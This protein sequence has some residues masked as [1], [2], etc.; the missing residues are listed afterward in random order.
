MQ[1]TVVGKTVTLLGSDGKIRTISKTNPQAGLIVRAL[2]DG[3]DEAKVVN[4]FD[5][6]KALEDFTLG[7]QSE[8]Q[9]ISITNTD[10]N[11]TVLVRNGRV[12]WDKNGSEEE[13]GGVIVDRIR[14]FMGAGLN[15]TPL[16]RFLCRLMANPSFNSRKQLYEFL[17]ALNMPITDR[18]TFLACKGL[19]IDYTDR[20]TGKFDNHPGVVNEMPRSAV[21]ENPNNH[22]S[23][24]F[25]VGAWEYA[26]TFGPK[27]V[28][29]E[30]DPADVVSVPGDHNAQKCRVTRYKVLCDMTE[31]LR[32]EFYPLT[33]RTP[34]A[35]LDPVIEDEPDPEHVCPE[36]GEDLDGASEWDADEPR[37]VSCPHCQVD[38][39]KNCE[40]VVEPEGAVYCSKCGYYVG[41]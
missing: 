31:P 7:V 24:G 38:V 25:H 16:A 6:A 36:C 4:L 34:K 30:V 22:C 14:K 2:L 21:D 11:G 9:A 3:D 19:N 27:C 29:V 33:D 13:L 39:C 15:A 10:V 5:A 37:K 12:F 18:G 1:F 41:N 17:E 8:I 28:L 20:H 26:S 40:E 35:E 23:N 32:G